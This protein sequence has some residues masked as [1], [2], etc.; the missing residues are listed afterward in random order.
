M[1]LF[2][3]KFVKKYRMVVQLLRHAARVYCYKKKR[4]NDFVENFGV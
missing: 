2:V 1:I 3:R 4:Q